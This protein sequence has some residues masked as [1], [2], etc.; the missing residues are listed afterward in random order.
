[1]KLPKIDKNIIFPIIEEL[2]EDKHFVENLATRLNI[3]QPVL[4]DYLSTVKDRYGEG[5]VLVGLLVFR[6]LESQLEVNELE[7]MF[8]DP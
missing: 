8:S 6:F 2:N 7:E 5:A 3:E 1:M 4:F